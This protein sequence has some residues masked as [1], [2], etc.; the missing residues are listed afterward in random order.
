MYR[1]SICV[2]VISPSHQG[3]KNSSPSILRSEVI[4]H[5]TK[6]TTCQTNTTTKSKTSNLLGGLWSMDYK[7]YIRVVILKRTYVNEHSYIA[8][9]YKK[10]SNKANYCI[11]NVEISNNQLNNWQQ[12]MLVKLA[13]IN[14][15]EVIRWLTD[16]RNL[17]I[18]MI[19][20]V[21]NIALKKFFITILVCISV[22]KQGCVH[23]Y[24][25]LS[26][27]SKGRESH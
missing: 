19:I 2:S 20:I 27:Q 1:E 7:V 3:F 16:T 15:G 26:T 25:R 21:S 17:I 6:T 13:N 11:N 8:E 5:F 9:L 12:P 24:Y 22:Y 18:H 4:I 23:T 14:T 10:W